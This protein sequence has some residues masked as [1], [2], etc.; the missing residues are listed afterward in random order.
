MRYQRHRRR[1]RRC[2]ICECG[3]LGCRLDGRR[4]QK[5]GLLCRR[6]FE[7]DMLDGTVFFFRSS[8]MRKVGGCAPNGLKT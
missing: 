8:S 1:G 7:E 3:L 2:A 6:L 4:D 5:V